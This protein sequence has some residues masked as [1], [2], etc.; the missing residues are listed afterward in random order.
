VHEEVLIIPRAYWRLL[1]RDTLYGT[2]PRLSSFVNSL[3]KR[4][5]TRGSLCKLPSQLCW[6]NL[7]Y[8]RQLVYTRRCAIP[9]V[10]FMSNSVIFLITVHN[11]DCIMEKE[12]WY[13]DMYEK[14]SGFQWLRCLRLGSAAA[15]LLWLQIRIPPGH[16]LLSLVS[17]V[18]FQIEFSG[19]GRS[20]VQRSP[21]ECSVSECNLETPTMRRS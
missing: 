16:G 6:R 11:T 15:R 12:N 21:T 7:P 18:C 13:W 5:P 19:S 20:L 3:R 10:V 4:Q 9:S 8:I 14:L 2:Q 1:V 17:V